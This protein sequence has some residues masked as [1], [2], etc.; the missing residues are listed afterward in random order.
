MDSPFGNKRLLKYSQSTPKSPKAG[1][2]SQTPS[3]DYIGAPL[4]LR[5]Q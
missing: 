3:P 4:F 2:Y 5:S 1:G